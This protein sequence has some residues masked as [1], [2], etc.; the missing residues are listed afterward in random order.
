MHKNLLPCP[1]I[2]PLCNG[3][4]NWHSEVSGPLCIGMACFGKTG[5][6]AIYNT[7][8]KL[9]RPRPS[10]RKLNS[11]AAVTMTVPTPEDLLGASEISDPPTSCHKDKIEVSSARFWAFAHPYS[12]VQQGNTG[13][14]F[15]DHLMAPVTQ[16]T[17]FVHIKTGK[18]CSIYITHWFCSEIWP[19]GCE[20]M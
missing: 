19:V 13:S 18:R 3:T 5:T 16:F 2:R 6:I 15:Y 17:H 1:R 14:N 7:M 20:L 12:N 8:I 9:W 10:Q 4:Y 11:C